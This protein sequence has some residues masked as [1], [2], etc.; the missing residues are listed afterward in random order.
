MR[1]IGTG[2]SVVQGQGCALYRDRGCTGTGVYVVQGQGC[3]LYKDSGCTG[4]GV[5]VVEGHVGRC[6]NTGPLYIV[7]HY[8]L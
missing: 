7:V 3:A 8:S 2:V 5:R 6:M 4:T 1:C